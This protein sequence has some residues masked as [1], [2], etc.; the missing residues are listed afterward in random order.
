MAAAMLSTF[1]RTGRL[2]AWL[3]LATTALAL[4]ASGCRRWNWRGE[5]FGDESGQWAQK[6]RPPA[7]ESRFS[8]ID[9]RS[10]EIERD[11]GVR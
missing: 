11:L 6:M 9:A 2:R 3:A 1:S 4:T 8:G 7:D 10:R 5:G